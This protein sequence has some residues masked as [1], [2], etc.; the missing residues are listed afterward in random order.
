MCR[1]PNHNVVDRSVLQGTLF[2]QHSE[3]L[4]FFSASKCLAVL[5][6]PTSLTRL[7]SDLVDIAS[8][9]FKLDYLVV[10]FVCLTLSRIESLFPLA[11]PVAVLIDTIYRPEQ[12]L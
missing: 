8:E 11:W 12:P 2:W 1:G 5:W 3:Q 7:L 6:Y 4:P 10:C 9:I